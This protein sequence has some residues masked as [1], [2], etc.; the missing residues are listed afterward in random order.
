M[1]NINVGLIG[2]GVAGRVFHAPMITSIPGLNLK[3]IR[4]TKAENI[5]IANL[6]YP[7]AEIVSNSEFILNDDSIDLVVI[8]TPNTSH[9]SLAEEALKAG[10][11]VIVDK[12]FTV[13]TAEADSLIEF[14]KSKNKVL[15]VY[16]NRRFDSTSKTIRK[17]ISSGMLGQLREYEVH[18]DRFR[19][20][21]RPGAWREE[22]VPGS[23]I[24][25]DLGAHLI[26]DAL[27]LFGLPEEITADLRIQ[28]PGGKTIDNF[29]VILH[30]PLLKVTLK[31]G[32]LVRE[33][34]P[35]VSLCGLNGSFI[36]YGMDVQEEALRAGKIPNAE[37]DWGRE[38][39]SLWGTINTEYQGLHFR[40]T[41]E[42]EP[43]DYR[44]FYANVY[45]ALIGQKE[46]IVKPEQAR[47]TI[48]I[49]E[50]A[51]RSNAEKRTV[52]YEH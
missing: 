23:G 21:F 41:I 8:A 40:G 48:R 2:F 28:R 42:S 9:F 32:M 36:K 16:H 22:D 14:A 17:V 20:Y 19:N 27:D 34:G 12:P 11:H 15:S 47:N 43:G 46:L 13:T 51:I 10:K 33:P 49:I 6:R 4:E 45:K 3:K 35:A 25:Y 31:G 52:R 38:P 30:Y 5:Q 37:P 44:D 39:E 1:K 18:Y 29:E 24:F 7:Y 50:L 26:D